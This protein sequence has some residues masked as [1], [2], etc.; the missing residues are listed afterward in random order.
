VTFVGRRRIARSS[1]A[2][3]VQVIRR[4]RVRTGRRYRLRVRAELRDGRQLT[5]DRRLRSCA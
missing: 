1:R 3:T 5:L 2:P 4:P